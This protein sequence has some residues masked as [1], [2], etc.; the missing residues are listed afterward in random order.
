MGHPEEVD[1]IVCGG[2]PAGCVVAGRL[3]YADPTLKVMLIEGGANNRDDPWVYR[4]G[5]YVRNMQRNGINDKATFYTD[6]M[7]SSYLRGRRSIVPCANILGGGSSINSQMYTRASASD[8]DDFKT[9]GWTCKDLLPLMKRLENYQKPCNNDTHGYDGPIAISNGGQIMPVAQDFLR[10]AHAIGVPYSDDI[11]DLTTAHG[12]EIWAKYINR[13]TG[14]RSDAA[15]AYVHSV[16]DV[17]DNL[18]LRCNA[19]VSRVLFDDNNKAVGV[20]YVPS[21]NRTHGG[22]LHETIVKARK[23][24][25]LS[26]G[27][28]GTPQI[29][30]RSGV[31]NG[32]LLRQL[33]IK[34]VSDLP[35]VGEQYQDHYTTLSIYR[36]SNESITTD[37]FLRGVKDVQRELFTEWEVSPEKARLSS[38]AIDAGFKIRPT[39]EELKEMG[40]EFNELWNRYFKDKPDKPVMFGSIV[41]GAYADHTLLPPGKYITMF[42]YLEYPASRGK[43][44]IKSQ[45]PYV[46]PFFDSGFMNNKA[47]F[48]PIRWSYKKTREVARRMDAFRG[49][50]TS[51]HPR[52]HPASPAA[53]KD[54]DIETAKQIYPD[55]LT[56]GI[57]MGSW[58]Q[59]SEPYKHDKV[60][61]DIPYTEEDDKAID[62]WVADHVETTWHSLGTCAMKPREQGG[63]VDKRLNVYGTQNL[64]CV[65]L[66]ICPDNLGTNT[67]SSALLVG[68]KGAD[69]IAEELGLKIKTPHAPVPHAPVPTGR[70]ATQQVR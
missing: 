70:P 55:G 1:V 15:T 49:E 22:K 21:R 25:V 33:G 54:I 56:V 41:A 3:A 35:G 13:H 40:P 52:F 7:A 2:G 29:L 10:A 24:V 17:Q 23:M 12:A 51:H 27:T 57:H 69:L 32:E 44:H 61:E 60:I 30:E 8:W 62:D 37:D 68:E 45:N 64:K 4:P 11:Q 50:L 43:I 53:C 63:V 65:D 67:Y 58:H 46:E 19:R 26:S 20:A 6:T 14:R 38:N 36:V 47:D 18:F 34:I 59:P 28:L 5:I 9:E 66:S 39:E 42:Q 16:M 31:G 48:A